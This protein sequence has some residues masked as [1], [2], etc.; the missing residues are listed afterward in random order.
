MTAAAGDGGDLAAAYDL[1]RR[2][3]TDLVR[4]TGTAARDSDV[5]R[6]MLELQAGWDEAALGFSKFSRF[7]RQAHDEEVVSLRRGDGGNYD[8]VAGNADVPSADES[9]DSRGGRDRGRGGRGRQP[10]DTSERDAQ[11]PSDSSAAARS[12]AVAP[13]QVAAKATAQTH[14]EASPITAVSTEEAVGATQTTA[15]A[16]GPSADDTPTGTAATLPRPVHGAV[17]FRRGSR[18][19]P[20]PSGPPPLLAGQAAPVSRIA[21]DQPR[22]HPQTPSQ[23]ESSRSRSAQ[24]QADAP[25]AARETTEKRAPARRKRPGRKTTAEAPAK[26]AEA[27]AKAAEAPAAEAPAKA[28]QP[29]AKDAEASAHAAAGGSRK[30]AKTAQASGRFDPTALGLPRSAGDVATY[31]ATTYSGI[32]PKSVEALIQRFGGSR[33]FDALENRPDQVREVMGSARGDRLLAAWAKDVRARRRA[34]G[35]KVASGGKN[36]TG[37][38]GPKSSPQATTTPD[39]PDAGEEQPGADKP[40]TSRGRRGGRRQ[41]RGQPTDS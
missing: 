10:R 38:K 7:L 4:K 39:A 15:P 29:A 19:R 33:V 12:E 32:G 21:A 20:A 2:A 1:L 18:G 34:S 8:V 11:W 25:A 24:P 36:T 22:I 35:G 16:L 28:P 31:I 40:R 27:P 17:G 30:A 13:A 6:R 37:D 41:R 3:T 14:V 5:K 26:A 23:Q 9:Q